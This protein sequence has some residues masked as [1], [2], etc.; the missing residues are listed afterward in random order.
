MVNDRTFFS[1]NKHLFPLFGLDGP[2][3]WCIVMSMTCCKC[4]MRY[5]ANDG[6]IFSSLPAY[7]VSS[8]PVEPTYALDKVCH[9]TK[10]A[11]MT[12]DLLMPTYGNGEL[13]SRLLYNAI[14]RAYVDRVSHYFSSYALHKTKATSYGDKN[15]HYITCYPPLGDTV[16]DAYDKASSYSYNPWGLSGHD[17]HTS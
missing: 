3:S 14:N 12:V 9:F 15:G 5:D 4:K 7:A 1:K 11:T 6:A 16:H 17:R 13:C 8:Y 10:S 2:P